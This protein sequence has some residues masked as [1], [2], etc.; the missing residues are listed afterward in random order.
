LAQFSQAW[1]QGGRQAEEL[2][3]FLSAWLIVHI[4][5]EDRAMVQGLS[6]VPGTAVQAPRALGDG[7][8]VLLDAVRTLHGALAGLN[9]SLDRRIQERTAE[10][11]LAN[12][13]LK[14]SFLTSIRMFTSMMELRG[15]MLAGHS[16]RVADL[17]R[18][19]ALRMGLDD[20]AVQQVFLGAA[21]SACPTNCW[22]NR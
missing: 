12:Q 22:A 17:A 20:N 16:R 11:A 15:G 8:Q 19:V 7:E 2:Q 13:R 18:R 4:L 21:R 14:G 10:L 6:Q 3:R 5:G 9:S 1:A